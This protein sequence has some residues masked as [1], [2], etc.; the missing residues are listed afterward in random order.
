M[1]WV[2]DRTKS[3]LV[4]MLMHAS[5]LISYTSRLMPS[6][7]GTAMMIFILVWS[8]LLWSFVVVVQQKLQPQTRQKW[9]VLPG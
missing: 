9:S 6:A 5:L 3:L 7:T 2:Y 8:A 4:V 1:V